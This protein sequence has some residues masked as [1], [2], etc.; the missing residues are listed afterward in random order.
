MQNKPTHTSDSENKPEPVVEEN[1]ADEPTPEGKK[2]L[3]EDFDKA[4]K[5]MREFLKKN[6]SLDP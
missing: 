5:Q 1:G 6:P 4:E 2:L 3:D